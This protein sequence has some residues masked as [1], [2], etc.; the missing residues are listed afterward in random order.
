MKAIETICA[1]REGKDGERR[2]GGEHAGGK[3]ADASREQENGRLEH[4]ESEHAGVVGPH[5]ADDAHLDVGH[6][7]VLGGEVRRA[8]GRYERGERERLDA[9]DRAQRAGD[10]GERERR[11]QGSPAIGAQPAFASVGE[12]VE[13]PEIG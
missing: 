4:A 13:R 6:D 12:A 5:D 10:G 1:P 2:R 9:R 11:R 3:V 7:Q 8:R